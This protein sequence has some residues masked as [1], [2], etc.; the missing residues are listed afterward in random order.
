MPI[1]IKIRNAGAGLFNMPTRICLY[2]S[3]MIWL[4]IGQVT[5]SD[6]IRVELYDPVND[7]WHQIL[8]EKAETL[9]QRQQGLM[10]RQF[11]P[12]N[13]GMLFL[14]EQESMLSFWMKNTFI[15]LDIIYFSANG[16]WVNTAHHTTPKS[17][18]TYPSLAP[19][20]F[21]LELPAGH[22]NQL[23]IGAGSKLIIKDCNMLKSGLDFVPCY[24]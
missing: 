20:Q 6:L 13:H 18:T 2:L 15:S 17:L 23:N 9:E 4:G 12:E 5:A 3:I 11:L 24:R 22:A 21:V 14:Y 19:A 10:Y 7:K 16:E 1:L 8:A